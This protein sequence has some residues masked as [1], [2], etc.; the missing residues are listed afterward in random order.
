M[1]AFL[2]RRALVKGPFG[3]SREWTAVWAVL[4]GV[5][6]LRRLTREKP[7]VLLCETLQPGESMLI[8]GID[9]EPQV[10]AGR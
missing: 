10:I 1:L 5:R 4:L 9:A 3:G 7:E 2:R 8:S 6:L